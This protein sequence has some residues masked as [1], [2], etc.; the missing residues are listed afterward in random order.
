MV[1]IDKKCD[2]EFLGTFLLR[3][4]QYLVQNCF[5]CVCV[6]VRGAAPPKRHVSG[7]KG[8]IVPRPKQVTS[9]PV[10]CNNIK[11]TTLV[12]IAGKTFTIM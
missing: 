3:S 2:F 8:I 5:V 12:V 11:E 6:R 10:R 4:I 9:P 1:S 7:E